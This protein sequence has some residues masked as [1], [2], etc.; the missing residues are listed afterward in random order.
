MRIFV[1]H[2]LSELLAR[3][4]LAV[5]SAHV[6]QAVYAPLTRCRRRRAT[7]AAAAA[8][9]EVEIRQTCSSSEWRRRHF[10]LAR[11]QQ[12]QPRLRNRRRRR[13]PADNDF[14]YTRCTSSTLVIV[15]KRQIQK[16]YDISS[17]WWMVNPLY[18]SDICISRFSQLLKKWQFD[19]G[20]GEK[21][22]KNWNWKTRVTEYYFRQE[23]SV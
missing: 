3:R 7:A 22:I 19:Q 5:H 6:V 11:Q 15:Y 20:Y 23:K 21:K 12:H 18:N 8:K 16:C 2:T 17:T 13:V 1:Y 14:V 9:R 10:L 4:A